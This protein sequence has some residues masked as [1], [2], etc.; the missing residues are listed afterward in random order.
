VTIDAA[1]QKADLGKVRQLQRG[2]SAAGLAGWLGDCSCS[3]DGEQRGYCAN[4]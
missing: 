4:S 1:M 2:F 3:A